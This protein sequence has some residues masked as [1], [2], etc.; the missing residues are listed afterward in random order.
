MTK[1]ATPHHDSTHYSPPT[2]ARDC[3][4]RAISHQATRMPDLGILTLD[5][6]GPDPRDSA[7]AHAIYDAV[8]TRWMTLSYIVGKLG[9]QT[10]R[11][12]EPRMQAVLLGGA[13][14]ILLMDRIPVHAVLDESVQW[15]KV[16]I[17]PG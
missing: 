13:A 7:L 3:A 1:D 14:Q 6:S 2:N 8:I 9:Q 12:L 15:A 17:R 11:D 5:T 16:N 4:L 10:M